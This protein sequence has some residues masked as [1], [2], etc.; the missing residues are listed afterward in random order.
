MSEYRMPSLGADMEAGTIVE[1]LVRPGDR[2]HRGDV[3]ARIET[4]KAT[5][6]S[7]IFEDGVIAALLVSAGERVAVGTPLARVEP[8]PASAPSATA[9]P[10]PPVP[11]PTRARPS[12]RH[13]A[14][15]EHTRAPAPRPAAPALTTY[16]PLVRRLAEERGV[17]LARVQGTGR[18]HIATRA[19]VEAATLASRAG[20]AHAAH[21]RAA[22]RARRRAAELGIDLEHVTGTGLAGEITVADVEQ[23]QPPSAG[24]ELPTREA[25][26]K[27]GAPRSR[28]AQQASLRHRIA[29]LMTRSK[30]E[31]PHYY[32]ATTV[33]FTAAQAWLTAQ[34]LTR[35]PDRRLLPVALILK[36]TARAAVA[37][38]EL[39]GLFVD[40]AFHASPSVHLGVAI[41]LRNGGL[42]APA[43]HSVE[44]L[45]LDTLMACLKDLVMRTR[46][47]RLR[48]SEMADPTLTVTNLG[49]QGVETVFGVIYPPQ[50]ALVGAGRIVE[51]PVALDGLIGIRP[52]VTLTLAADHRVSDGLSGARFLRQIDQSLQ[53]PEDL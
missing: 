25:P 4:E 15:A 43:L 1:W 44:T 38:P 35:S 42:V 47:G 5:I 19:D 22:P 48:S 30:R 27:P 26:A 10:A 40:G 12:R 39:N 45:D 18:A 3:V 50:V 16:S 53:E 37:V 52:L 34:N 23:A 49:E 11:A 14:P 41:S 36:A 21:V 9:A 13:P 17:E 32:L 51:Q 29:E 8:S 7:E 24:A 28:A 46:T 31:I 6:D 20:P 33:D 2:V